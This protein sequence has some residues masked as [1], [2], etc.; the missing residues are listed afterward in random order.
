[1]NNKLKIVIS[2]FIGI[3]IIATVGVV[4]FIPKNA[5]IHEA[6][7]AKNTYTL[8]LNSQWK[9]PV[10]PK[11]SNEMPLGFIETG[12]TY[13]NKDKCVIEIDNFKVPVNNKSKDD[14]DASFAFAFP[15]G[16][17]VLKSLNN[18]SIF[19]TIVSN[20]NRTIEMIKSTSKSNSASFF[21]DYENSDV[22][23]LNR[24]SEKS[25][26]AI[27]IILAC[28]YESGV[29]ANELLKEIKLESVK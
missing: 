21:V 28:P 17:P 13:I 16:V 14:F 22:L 25:G 26:V 29:K 23:T 18:D 12:N 1:M 27:Q 11:T 15:D 6:L 3:T 20:E 9:H 4:L 24:M 2:S 5:S 7:D 10:A 19:K 8:A